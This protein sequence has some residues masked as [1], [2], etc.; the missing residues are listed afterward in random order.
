MEIYHPKD[1]ELLREMKRVRRVLKRRRLLWGFMITMVLTAVFG[2][3]VFYRY[4]SLAVM[5]GPGMANTLPDGSLVLVIRNEGNTYQRND[6][7]LYETEQGSQIKR[8][9]AA[10]NDQVVVGPRIRVNGEYI[11]PTYTVGRNADA[12]L[13]IRRMTIEKGKLFVQGDQLSLSVDSRDP[14]YDTID[15][16]KVTGKVQYVLWPFYKIGEIRTPETAAAGEQG[17]E[18]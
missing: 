11:D 9:I 6:I 16:E 10:E 4:C 3:F 18:V 17:G 1:D 15:A 12:G 13:A 7:I 14:A 2:W 8:V 5:R